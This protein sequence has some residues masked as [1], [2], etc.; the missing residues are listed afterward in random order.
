M[1]L[2]YI[3]LKDIISHSRFDAN[4]EVTHYFLP[5]LCYVTNVTSNY[6]P[7]RLEVCLF[8]LINHALVVWHA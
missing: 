6:Q 3:K 8:A 1:V 5:L 4:T 2:L 7:G